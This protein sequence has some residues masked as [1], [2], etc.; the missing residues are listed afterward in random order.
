M[1]S[2]IFSAK[3]LDAFGFSLFIISMIPLQ[4]TVCSDPT[5]LPWLEMLKEKFVVGSQMSTFTKINKSCAYIIKQMF[6][7]YYICFSKWN[8][9]FFEFCVLIYCE[10]LFQTSTLHRNNIWF[11]KI[12]WHFFVMWY[13]NRKH[14]D[15]ANKHE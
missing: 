14:S 7:S 10:K 2:L 11:G 13:F 4:F 1:N 12:S 3:N 5:V 6:W 8:C 15:R 9:Y